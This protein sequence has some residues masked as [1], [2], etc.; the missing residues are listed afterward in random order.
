MAPKTT[1]KMRAPSKIESLI[2][3]AMI[4][5][6]VA[7][8]LNFL[9]FFFR[10]E[11]RGYMPLYI[12]LSII[13]LYGALKKFYLWYHY[14]SISVPQKPE[15]TKDFTV[16][17]LTTY[18]P[19]EPYEMTLTTLK[20]IQEMEYPHTTYL[21]DEANDAYLKKE[22]AKLGVIH[23]TRDNRID[24]KAG[25]INNALKMATGEICLILD[26]DHIPKP[27]FLN[28]VL[29][30]FKDEKIGFVQVV[31]AYFNKPHTLV[32]R[33]AAEQTFQFYGPMMMTM[34]TYG[35]V[36]AI[37]A[38]CTFRRSALDSIGGHAPGLAEDMHTA[39][40]L[41]AKGWK[42][43]Y[44][45]E[46]LAKGLVPSD[47]TSYFKQQLKWSRGTFELLY[48]VYPRIFKNLTTRQKIHYGLLPLHYLIGLIYLL[49]FLLPIASLLLSKMPWTG[50][51]LYFIAL[52]LPVFMSSLLI[53]T[54]IQKWVIEKSERGFHII[55]GLLQITAWWVFLVGVVYTFIRKKVP[56]L[57]T[58]KSEEKTNY[59]ILV[60]NLII[61][62]LSLFAVVY[63]LYTDLTPFSIVMAGFAI[64]NAVFMFFSV[65]LASK[66]TN[67]N[68]ILRTT[69]EQQTINKLKAFKAGI[70]RFWDY[71]FQF[72]RL[73]ALPLLFL[74]IYISYSSL[75]S[76]EKSNW[77][78]IASIEIIKKD[79]KYLGVFYPSMDNGISDLDKIKQLEQK[80]DLKFQIVS[81]YLP[82]GDSPESL[83]SK[84]YLEQ[85]NENES[86][87][88]VSWEPWSGDFAISDSISDLKS[89]NRV[90]HYIKEGYF[91]D[92]IKKMAL[93]IKEF[94]DPV[95]LRFAHEFDNPSYPWSATGQ[96]TSEEFK[97][98]W[99]HVHRLFSSLKVDNVIW[100]WNPWKDDAFLNYYPGDAYVD[101][102][103]ITLL[104]Y[105]KLN[106][107]GNWY[108]FEDLY[109]PY[110]EKLKKISDKPVLLAE[111]GSLT[112]GGDQKLW[113]KDA[114]TAIDSKFKE[115]QGLVFFNSK[116][117][118]NIPANH[119]D[120]NKEYLDWTFSSLGA[121]DFSFFNY[122][123]DETYPESARNSVDFKEN[124][125]PLPI[126]DTY[127]GIGYKKARNWKSNNY[128]A[129][130]GTLERDFQLM[131]DAGID[132]IMYE[133]ST[134]YDHN[135]LKYTKNNGLQVLYSFP[136]P[137]SID[138]VRDHE[139]LNELKK[140]ILIKVEELKYSDNIMGWNL[141]NDVWLNLDNEHEDFVILKEQRKAYLAW[142]VE[143]VE[144]IK[145]LD[146]NRPLVKDISL[147]RSALRQIDA[148]KR[149]NI[150]LDAFG[151][152]VDNPDYL[153][154]FLNFA[155][156]EKLAYIISGIDVNSL[157]EFNDQFRNKPVIVANWQ[158]QWESYKVT[159][160][161]LLDFDG[162]KKQEFAMLNNIW[163]TV[164]LDTEMPK[165]RVLRP[166][167]PLLTNRKETYQAIYY[168]NNTW[169]YPNGN[170][171]YAF[172]WL[173]AKNDDFGNTLA[174]RKLGKEHSVSIVVPEDYK[175]YKLILTIIK[176][177]FTESIETTLNTPLYS[178]L[179]TDN[180]NI[181]K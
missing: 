8:I 1:K 86:I 139:E 61:A 95:F 159:F 7:S 16:D 66:V 60:P 156:K 112:L 44:V 167:V 102:V 2:V 5:I 14:F 177:E 134:I 26:P 31:Q 133:Q 53:G 30:Y 179:D 35:T 130:R 90:L 55:G 128:V 88:M 100:V 162:R 110:Y 9:F 138:F 77:D 173:L 135:V 72:V 58:P 120:Y 151:I 22:C 56:Y 176:D 70:I 123:K 46:V 83:L 93:D 40:L 119:I 157:V 24:A 153:D 140:N 132:L 91:D 19:G 158:N 106:S 34:N 65:Y 36:N 174:I 143:L 154:D 85:I 79:V 163:G 89:G 71:V 52:S 75:M 73:L 21:C 3:R 74:S 108:T 155:D 76:M 17:V 69:L 146:P 144:A 164:K 67:R 166:A 20:A 78:N 59:Y 25:N 103:G 145:R 165:F 113:L 172:E 178:T 15:A 127:K 82:W 131:Q 170:D 101:W 47:L 49:G 28:V 27:N 111:F 169:K 136:I 97:L 129:D 33:G 99:Q 12:L 57:P 96:N 32:A 126:K 87:P 18:F 68:K 160:D 48:S 107:D 38:N 161:G 41:H 148:F 63:G 181:S 37:G 13:L 117:D 62:F 124:Y 147:S 54:F 180:N 64:L 122:Y 80:N 23:V 152:L 116:F 29:P 141:A 104:N 105:G 137:N 98:A 6:G 149:S 121:K 142:L 11:F 168:H 115:I 109:N 175:N 45:P 125:I 118:N 81:V 50:N 171:G 94:D 114:F 4:I 84:S 43:V 150:K 39:M 10:P 92:Y 42:S 51:L